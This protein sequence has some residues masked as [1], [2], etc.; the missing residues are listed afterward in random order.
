M[1][2]ATVIDAVRFLGIGAHITTEDIDIEW[3]QETLLKPLYRFGEFMGYELSHDIDTTWE[4][5]G[6][7][8]DAV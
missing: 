7:M 6:G 4:L 5:L 8:K 3:I 2:F 1:Y